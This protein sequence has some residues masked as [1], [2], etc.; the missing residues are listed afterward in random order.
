VTVT[1]AE[2]DGKTKLTLHQTVLESFAMRTGAYSS[3]LEMVD[4]LVEASARPGAIDPKGQTM[5]NQN[6]AMTWIGWGISGLI[7]LMLLA[8]ATMKLLSPPDMVEQFVDKLG[9]PQ[10]LL[11][12]L[13]ITE[14]SC[15]IVYLIPRTAILGAVLLTGYLGGAIATHVRVQDNFVPPVIGGVLVWLAVYLRDPRVR[16]LLPLRRPMTSAESS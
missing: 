9:Y 12:A 8:S 16:A 5:G 2:L 15:V 3:W 7:G 6:K 4:G 1:F 11:L 13:A 10:H 14:V